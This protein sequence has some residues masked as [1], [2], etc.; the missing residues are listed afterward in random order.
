VV[1]GELCPGTQVKR[2][3]IFAY[4]AG[5][6][7]IDPTSFQSSMP[8][9]LV[10]GGGPDD[11]IY[12]GGQFSTVNGVTHGGLVELNV[13][14]GVTSG[15]TADGSVVSGFDGNVDNKCRPSPQP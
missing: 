13:R 7:Q 14:P 9:R 3:D 1:S 4:S 6:G 10:R 11:T 5:S 12:V 8:A 2:D 15:T